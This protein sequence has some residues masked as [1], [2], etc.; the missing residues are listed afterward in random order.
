MVGFELAMYFQYSQTDMRKDPTRM[1]RLRRFETDEDENDES[2]DT[3]K[4]VA[5]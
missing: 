2:V 5:A 1:L 4:L 3:I